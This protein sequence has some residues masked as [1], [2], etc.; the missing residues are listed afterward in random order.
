M[1]IDKISSPIDVA[2]SGLRAE[3]LRMK[4]IANNIA[5][6]H[7]ERTDAGVPYRRQQVFTTAQ[8]AA[9]SGVEEIRVA[10]DPTPFK[11]V[12]DPGNPSAGENGFVLMPNV[13]VPREMMEMVVASR[14]YQAN[15]AIL[16]RYQEGVD[17]A[18]ELLR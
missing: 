11:S 2:V 3:A 18:L 8:K 9:M 4:V 6:A 1:P 5:N 15:A 12:F 7:T 10:D 17:V 14:A 13:D 16:K